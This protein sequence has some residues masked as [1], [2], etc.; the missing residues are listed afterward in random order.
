LHPLDNP[1]WQALN[2][3]DSR[4]NLGNAVVGYFAADVCPFAA[5]P[6]WSEANQ[7]LLYEQLPTNRSWSVMIKET[8]E[9][10]GIWEIKFST[11]LHQM[12]CEKLL[13]LTSN[14]V[15]CKPLTQEHVPAMLKLTALTKPGPFYEHTI[16]FGNYYGIFDEEELVAMAGERLH[17]N[18]YTEISAVCTD[19][20]YT[21]KGYG[22]ILVSHIAQQIIASG[23]QP[24][25]HV[26]WDNQRAIKMYERIGFAF[27][28]EV[29]FA[30]FAER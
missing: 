30:V 24:F 6:D 1:V 19:P 20:D 28:T 17:L 13:P 9:F 5:L 29:F 16:D 10:T 25:L 7:K 2:T 26:K 11:T 22:A 4:F 27:R 3:A 8:V 18:G 15:V 14:E 12:V 21:G 23:R